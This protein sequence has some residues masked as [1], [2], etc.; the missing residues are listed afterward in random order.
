[1]SRREIL[2]MGDE[3]LLRIAEPVTAFDTP[4]LHALIADMRE[5]MA[6]VNGAGL[7][8]PQIGVKIGRAHV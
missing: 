4:E 2:K 6:A 7:A 3:R 1:M 8:A 5:T